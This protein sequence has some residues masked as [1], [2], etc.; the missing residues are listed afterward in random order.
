MDP[1]SIATASVS[2]AIA[3]GQVI[4]S[5]GQFVKQ[6]KE[7]K[8][9]LDLVVKELQSLSNVLQLMSADD[10]STTLRDFPPHLRNRFTEIIGDCQ[11]AV[12]AVDKTL[13]KHQTGKLQAVRWAQSGS[14]EVN[15]LRAN[16]EIHKSTFGIVLGIL[17]M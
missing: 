13:K 4:S 11:G 1:F 17:S 7:A 9:D 15:S 2:L 6:V 5:I 16:L 3:I 12:E 14:A 10:A 8:N